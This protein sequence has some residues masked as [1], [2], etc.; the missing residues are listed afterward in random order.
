MDKRKVS[1]GGVPGDDLDERAAKR[2]KP[3]GVSN[4]LAAINL[5]L[6]QCASVEVVFGVLA[7]VAGDWKRRASS[8]HLHQPRSP[9]L[10]KRSKADSEEGRQRSFVDGGD[11]RKHYEI[12]PRIDRNAQENRR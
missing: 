1:G 2:R 11:S 12:G 4:P 5:R 8:R 10:L 7:V 3:S 6:A 9:H